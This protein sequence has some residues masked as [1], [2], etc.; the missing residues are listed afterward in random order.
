MALIVNRNVPSANTILGL[1]TNLGIMV[2]Q[3]GLGYPDEHACN[4]VVKTFQ[5]SAG[6]IMPSSAGATAGARGS[7]KWAI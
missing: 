6:V 1:V 5:S 3:D 2:S 4:N 7:I